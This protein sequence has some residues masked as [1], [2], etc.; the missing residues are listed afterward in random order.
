MAANQI[1]SRIVFVKDFKF[2]KLK[3]LRGI[4]NL[5]FLCLVPNRGFAGFV[6]GPNHGDIR[7]GGVGNPHFGTVQEVMISFV[8]KMRRH[9]AGVG[10]VVGFG[11]A[12]TAHPFAGGQ[13][14]KVFAALFFGTVFVDGVHHQRTLNRSRGTNTGIAAFQFL[15]DDAVG[16]F[17]HA[18]LKLFHDIAFGGRSKAKS[19]AIAWRAKLASY[20]IA[21]EHF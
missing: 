21:Q 14:G 10:P 19:T 20:C 1:T 15:H 13:F 6:L 18:D 7:K 8:H 3:E 4:S 9:P 12:K 17:V 16:D 5:K 2:N 11:Q